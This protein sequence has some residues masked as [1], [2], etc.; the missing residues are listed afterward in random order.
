MAHECVFYMQSNRSRGLKQLTVNFSLLAEEEAQ[1]VGNV[2]R[3]SGIKL[4]NDFPMT[5]TKSIDQSVS[6]LSVT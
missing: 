5:V 6:H 2:L 3:F 1:E 4:K